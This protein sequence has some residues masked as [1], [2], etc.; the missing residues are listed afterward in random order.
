M[1]E[2]IH[3][4]SNKKPFS[5]IDVALSTIPTLTIAFFVKL[6]LLHF[7]QTLR[8]NL[9][10]T[11]HMDLPHVHVLVVRPGVASTMEL[12]LRDQILNHPASS[13]TVFP[14]DGDAEHGQRT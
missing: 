5:N 3:F 2:F 1:Y 11:R 6:R 7:W 9:R 14:N 10:Q 13:N 12:Q 8:S 4:I